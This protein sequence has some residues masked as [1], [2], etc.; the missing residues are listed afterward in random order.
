[1]FDWIYVLASGLWI[2]V[3]SGLLGVGGGLLLVP[4]LVYWSP[5]LLGHA[6]VNL[7]LATGVSAVQGLAGTGS[8][9]WVHWQ[10]G[11]MERAYL[12]AM[13]PGAVLGALVGGVYSKE[14]SAVLLA[15]LMIVVLMFTLYTGWRAFYRLYYGPSTL[16]TASTGSPTT[17]F[18]PLAAQGN[19]LPMPSQPSASVTLTPPPLVGKRLMWAIVASLAIGLLSGLLGIGGAIFLLPLLFDG[20]GLPVKVAVGT[21]S[22]I[23]WITSLGSVVGKGTSGLIPWEVAVAVAITALIGGW[24][25]AHWQGRFSDKGLRLLNLCL[26]SLALVEVLRKTLL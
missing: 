26:L 7:P 17:A 4:A 13:M 8:G 1:M 18:P 14:V 10:A 12:V 25:G 9:A 15:W 20:F 11:R 23:V 22:A 21:V 3:L 5:L 2:G 24:I 6:I 16:A 19:A